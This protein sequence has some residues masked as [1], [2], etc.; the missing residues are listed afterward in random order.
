M[1]E[2]RRNLVITPLPAA[3]PEVGRWLGVLA[4]TRA[5]TL[6]TLEELDPAALDWPVPGG[7]AIGTLLAHIAAIEM[8]W[9]YAEILEQE[10]PPQVLAYLPEAVRDAEGNLFVVAGLPLEEHLARLAAT[11]AIFVSDLQ[12]L[13]RDDFYRPRS[14]PQ[15]DVTPEWVLHHLAHHEAGHRS[16]ILTV[17]REFARCTH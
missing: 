12:R 7:N 4:D 8:D 16:D 14:L 5:R 6:E 9:L 1:N 2:P 17:M 3:T 10:I 15:Y 11:R 13:S